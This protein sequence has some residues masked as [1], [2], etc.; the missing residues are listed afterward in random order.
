[1]KKLFYMLLT[2]ITF[3]ACSKYQQVLKS[4]DL[5]HKLEMAKKYYDEEEYFK[6]LPI[7]DE[8]NT[9]Y[10]GTSKA[11]EIYYYLAY[12]HYGLSENLVAGYH[13][14]NFALH[15]LTASMPKKWL[16]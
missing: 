15:F 12:T 13:F 11:E 2:T 6:A 4:P 8:L 3:S 16:I 5:E 10:R 9:L 1:M 7:F 14:R